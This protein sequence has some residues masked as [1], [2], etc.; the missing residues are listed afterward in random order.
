M[1]VSRFARLV[2]LAC[3]TLA[4]VP[5]AASAAAPRM[6][7]GFQD[8][9]NFRWND[10]RQSVLD[11]ALEAHATVIRT[12]VYWY[13]A[14]PSRPTTASDPFDNAYQLSDVDELVRN[15][16]MRGIS[17][18]ITIWGTPS[19]ANGGKGPNFV[20]TNMAD[21]TAF[22][23]AVAARYSGR[24]AGYPFVPFISIWNEPN[25]GQFLSP[26]YDT[27]GK[28]IAPK[29]YAALA[30]AGYAGVKSG[31][32]AA[33]V[34]IGETS[35]RGLDRVLGSTTHQETESP[36]KF[37]ELLAQQRPLVRFDAWAQ[38]PYPTSPNLA[39]TQKVKWPN[40]TLASLPQL[41]TSLDKWFGRKNIPI[42]I[43]EYGHQTSPPYSLGVPLAT[44]AA[45][46][47]QAL[48]IAKQDPRVQMFVWFVLKDDP[49]STWASGL[50]TRGGALKPAFTRFA[51]AAETVDML[52]GIVTVKAGKADPIVRVSALPIA[53]YSPPGTPLG[54]TWA[55]YDSGK[56]AGV[57]QPVVGLARDGWFSLPLTGIVPKAG[58]TYSLQ[59]TATDPNGNAVVRTLTLLGQK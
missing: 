13:K 7:I 31:N 6:W 28:A 33:L 44:Q 25:L 3:L 42:W 26:Q 5:V 39:P 11:D 56:P 17:V 2:V 9:P 23:H 54:V 14:A 48:A 41:E 53:Y 50:I 45:Y 57:R 46:T 43:T 22:A 51:D 34:G 32:P 20:P 52:N 47:A 24:Y 30:R 18:Y 55:L 1:P 16:E 38:H 29:L 10:A 37:A 8:D 36:G 4:F 21:L 59:V 49:G 35:N 40:V 58:H 12:T 27:T 15:A 19:W